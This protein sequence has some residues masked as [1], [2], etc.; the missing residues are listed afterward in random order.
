MDENNIDVIADI[1]IFHG[2]DKKEVC[3]I[4]KVKHLSLIKSH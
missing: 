4:G 2:Q 3:Y 1:P